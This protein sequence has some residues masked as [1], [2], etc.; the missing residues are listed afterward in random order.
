MSRTGHLAPVRAVLNMPRRRKRNRLA[1]QHALMNAALKLF[2]T[3]GYDATTTREI[4]ASAGCAEGLIHRYFNGKSGLLIALMSTYASQEVKDLSTSLPTEST[5]EGEVLQIVNW[6]VER[7]WKDRDMF[8]VTIPHAILDP[9]VGKFVSKVGPQ[10]HAKAIAERLRRHKDAGRIGN[11]QIEAISN[12]IG[13]MGFIFG[14]MRPAVLGQDRKQA[15]A[16]ASEIARI[17][18]RGL[19]A[20]A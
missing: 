9:K 3:R 14:F 6:E 1:K 12:A 2:A 15:A 20:A 13:A 18:S 17:L 7:I 8:R 16:Y 19:T 5:L 10:R 4:A 11:R